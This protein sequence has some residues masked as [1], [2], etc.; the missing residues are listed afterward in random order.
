MKVVEGLPKDDFLVL[1]LGF[2]RSVVLS[3]QVLHQLQAFGTIT[4]RRDGAK[5][6]LVEEKVP[7]PAEEKVLDDEAAKEV[8]P[9]GRH[10]SRLPAP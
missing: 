4:R 7:K 10:R 3:V 2:V 1:T 6:S 5:G 9:V 8:A